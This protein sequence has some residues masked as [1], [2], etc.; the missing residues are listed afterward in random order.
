MFRK[1]YLQ[2]YF[3]EYTIHSL[4]LY[5]ILNIYNSEL[6]VSLYGVENNT[7]S[8]FCL[9]SASSIRRWIQPDI[10]DKTGKQPEMSIV[11]VIPARRF[12]FF[13]QLDMNTN[14]SFLRHVQLFTKVFPYK[15]REEKK[16]NENTTWTT[17]HSDSYLVFCSMIFH[18][19]S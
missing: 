13:H 16:R 18:H 6:I 1:I 7:V 19:F 4:N 17:Y 9:T 14:P 15:R 8:F 10:S 12:S 3:S 11:L 2:M 5:S